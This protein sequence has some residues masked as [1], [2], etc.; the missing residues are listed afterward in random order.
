MDVGLGVERDGA[1]SGDGG[2]KGQQS[3]R[4]GVGGGGGGE[5]SWP[6]TFR[7]G[8]SGD[9]VNVLAASVS[10]AAGCSGGAVCGPIETA[11]RRRDRGAGCDA[12]A[13][14]WSHV[15]PPSLRDGRDCVRVCEARRRKAS[16]RGLSAELRPRGGPSAEDE[17]R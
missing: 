15:L 14:G 1:S 17:V 5:T 12:W 16:S 4:R 13:G 9:G 10:A 2:G 6:E 3:P 8:V 7:R 11:S